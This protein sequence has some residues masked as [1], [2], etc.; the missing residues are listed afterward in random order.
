[1]SN[2]TKT[3]FT[4]VLGALVV[5]GSLLGASVTGKAASAYDGNWSVSIQAGNGD[6]KASHLPL[7]IDNG[8]LGYNG[9]VPVS[10]SG[11]VGGNGSVS[12]S[13][14]AGGRSARASGQLSGNS[15]SGTW[16]GSSASSSCSG[17]WTASRA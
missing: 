1:M 2:S 4:G 13:L 16:T 12:V 8:K 14:K 17:T 11:S 7:K 15:G 6:C 9:Y 5:A 10:V 3:I